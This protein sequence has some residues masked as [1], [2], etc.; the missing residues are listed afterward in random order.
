MTHADR[1]FEY[2]AFVVSLTALVLFSR[3]R[4]L[5]L[6]LRSTEEESESK[7]K[8]VHQL[9]AC[10]YGAH[11]RAVRGADGPPGVSERTDASRNSQSFFVLLVARRDKLQKNALDGEKV[12]RR[13]R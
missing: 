12:K 10:P 9:K 6:R 13:G 1:S 2:I 7:K 11:C 3:V 8:G 5:P 4:F